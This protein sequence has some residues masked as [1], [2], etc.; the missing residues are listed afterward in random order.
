MF[1]ENK[2]I[3]HK[4]ERRTNQGKNQH[5]S[6]DFLIFIVILPKTKKQKK[7]IYTRRYNNKTRFIQKSFDSLLKSNDF[8]YWLWCVG[9]MRVVI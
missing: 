1:Q 5:I 8:K 9:E 4:H 6:N 2:A 3:N 7:L